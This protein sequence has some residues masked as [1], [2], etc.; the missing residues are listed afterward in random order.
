MFCIETF[1]YIFQ[2]NDEVPLQEKQRQRIG[3]CQ[4]SVDVSIFQRVFEETSKIGGNLK[5]VTTH[6]ISKV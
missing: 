6:N 2:E 3:N 1:F 5:S 4:S